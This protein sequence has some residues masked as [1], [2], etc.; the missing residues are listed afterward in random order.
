MI[1]DDC[2]FVVELWGVV[3]GMGVVRNFGGKVGFMLENVR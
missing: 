1:T 2:V 3:L